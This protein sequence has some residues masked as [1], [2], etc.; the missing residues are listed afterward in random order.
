[1]SR[2]KKAA[3]EIDVSP[4]GTPFR[5]VECWG[6]GLENDVVDVCMLG[7]LPWARAG[8]G[9]A[10]YTLVSKLDR[11]DIFEIETPFVAEF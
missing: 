4:S 11:K 6:G 3:S 10:L 7:G 5:L 8:A 9:A 2:F 1:M